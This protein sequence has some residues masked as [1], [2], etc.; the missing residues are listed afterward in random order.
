VKE[1]KLNG[2]CGTLEIPEFSLAGDGSFVDI[3]NNKY[4]FKISKLSS[5]QDSNNYEY[6]QLQDDGG[7]FYYT[8]VSRVNSE[9]ILERKQSINLLIMLNEY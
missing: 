3:N 5:G 8:I 6:L 7:L 2:I 1:C 9:A 4:E